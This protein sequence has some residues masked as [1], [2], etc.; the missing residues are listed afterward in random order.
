MNPSSNTEGTDLLLQGITS[1]NTA[2]SALSFH[3]IETELRGAILMMERSLSNLYQ[4]ILHGKWTNILG[5]KNHLSRYQTSYLMLF[6]CTQKL[7]YCQQRR[8]RLTKKGHQES[9][10]WFCRSWN[11]EK[12]RT[13]IIRV[14][15]TLEC[16]QDLTRYLTS[17]PSQWWRE[18]RIRDM[19]L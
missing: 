17:A 13:L 14:N 5:G 11:E 10:W 8:A 1:K 2:M 9:A 4:T 7:A 16:L 15:L 6:C 18:Q 19:N 12:F 3:R